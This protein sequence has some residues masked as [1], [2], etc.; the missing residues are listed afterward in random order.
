MHLQNAREKLP[1]H[2]EPHHGFPR[3]L[4]LSPSSYSRKWTKVLGFNFLAPP[5]KQQTEFG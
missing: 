1:R 3:S 2:F 5:K 4:S